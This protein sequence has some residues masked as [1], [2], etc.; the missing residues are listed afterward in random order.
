M[1]LFHIHGLVAATLATFASGGSLIAT[2]GCLAPSFFGWLEDFA[3]TWY[4]AV[5][6][7]HQTLVARARHVGLTPPVGRLRFVR[8][9]S[10]PLPPSLIPELES[11]F[12]APVIEA[13]GM[14]E[15]AHQMASNPLPP[16][17][18]KPGSVGV[19]AGPDVAIRTEHESVV[20]KPDVVGEVVIRG[21]NVTSGY[22][23]NPEAN[24]AAFT[25]GWFRTGDQGYLDDQGYLY[26][27][28]RLKEL[29]NRG[30]EKI[31]PREIDDILSAHPA[32]AQ[33]L[34][35]AVPDARLGEAVGAAVVLR[36][37]QHLTSGEL[38]AFAARQLAD[39]KVPRHIVFVGELPK[40][41]TG[42][43]QRVGAAERLGL[44]AA[45]PAGSSGK[46]EAGPPTS[47]REQAV[48]DAFAKVL[49][50]RD[51]AVGAS[52]FEL[53]GDSLL[54]VD[55]SSHLAAATGIEVPAHVLFEHDTPSALGAYLDNHDSG[56]T[57]VELEATHA[58]VAPLSF[59]Q[60][61][62]WTIDTLFRGGPLAHR[63]GAIR[64][65]GTLDS[66]ALQGALDDVVARHRVLGSRIELGRGRGPSQ[67]HGT[68]PCPQGPY[69]DAS[70]MVPDV[71]QEHLAELAQR[72]ARDGFDLTK[73]PLLRT[74]LVK[75]R[76]D[77]HVLLMN[78]HHIA[79]DGWSMSVLV[80]DLS[81]LYAARKDGGP[82]RLDPLPVQ[83][84]DYAAWHR[85]ALENGQF[86]AAIDYWQKQLGTAPQSFSPIRVPDTD[87]RRVGLGHERR[88]TLRPDLVRSIAAVARSQGATPF[89]G[90]LAAFGALCRVLGA[91]DDLV[92]GT[93]VSGRSTPKLARLVGCFMNEVAIRIDLSG[94]P[95]AL[96]LLGRMQRV[97]SSALAAQEAPFAHLVRT[98]RPTGGRFFDVA[99]QLRNLPPATARAEDVTFEDMPMPWGLA[100][101]DLLVELTP[102]QTGTEV[103]FEYREGLASTG[104]ELEE[105][106]TRALEWAAS[107]D[108][109]LSALEVST[110]QRP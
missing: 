34:A 73:G 71:Q 19:A 14:T 42:K 86:G 18:R 21:D 43:L 83:F 72:L 7:M 26:L 59:Q 108:A 6:T 77:E 37:G 49:G 61:F 47:S 10:A 57:G 69:I 60:E 94:D 98:L 88:A 20:T 40:G 85:R 89:V 30:G 64:I 45:A 110:P 52:F 5:P 2:P 106:F 29:I 31:A 81:A 91:P 50:L 16:G 93:F 24:E 35:F 9:S 84:A 11:L 12:G 38:L 87:P 53:G 48:I 15:A 8:S 78:V 32:V 102:G 67:V 95:T 103:R 105:Q 74:Q 56:R 44:G 79:F 97:A 104:V 58:T 22:D 17:V 75:L 99:F 90:Y 96:G 109:R 28:G 27:T 101:F 33:A 100:R 23:A 54:A 4:T 65:V 51:V 13:Y 92:F 46:D 66:D 107:P 3:P 80:S 39:F 70:G 63:P 41:P 76:P 1:P 82:A 25:D 36:P 55:L 68:S 62:F